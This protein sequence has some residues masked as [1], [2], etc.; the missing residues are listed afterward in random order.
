M[1]ENALLVGRGIRKSFGHVEALRG[2]DFDVPA[3]SITGL[4]GDNG[5]GKSTLIGVLSGVLQPD[6]G[7]ILLEGEG[8]TL[9]D[10]HAARMHGIET[11]YQDL[12]LAPELEPAMNI[13]L[14]RE[15]VRRGVLGRLSFIDRRRMRDETARRL[16]QLGIELPR[17]DRPVSYLS[18]GQRQ[19]V[20]IARALIWA[21]RVLLLDEPTAAL[22]VRQSRQVHDV[23]RRVRDQGVTVV[24]ISHNIADVM[25][26]TDRIIAM[27]LGRVEATFDTARTS[28]DEV[29]AALTGARAA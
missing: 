5:A 23:I 19:A 9:P 2:V 11:V 4:V 24:L 21:R 18:G 12:A 16:A 3:G 10:P 29:V 14:G 8:V 27:R 6:S 7:S 25:A 1:T 28:G 26:L 20:A 13:Y 15:I 17:L 22:G